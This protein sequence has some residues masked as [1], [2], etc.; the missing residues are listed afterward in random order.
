MADLAG[1]LNRLDPVDGH[2]QAAWP[3]TGPIEASPLEAEGRVYWVDSKGLVQA[4]DL[5]SGEIAWSRELGVKVEAAPAYQQGVSMSWA[6]RG[7]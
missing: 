5:A 7:G 3:A 2:R 4:L 1:D 6:A